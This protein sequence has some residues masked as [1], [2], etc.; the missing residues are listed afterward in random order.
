MISCILNLTQL[1]NSY[2]EQRFEA[3]YVSDLQ[4][5]VSTRYKLF[6]QSFLILPVDAEAF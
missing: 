4:K 6:V 2:N 3:L 1:I 5:V